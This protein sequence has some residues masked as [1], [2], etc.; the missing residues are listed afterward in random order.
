MVPDE[1]I[2]FICDP[3]SGTNGFFTGW[4]DDAI[5]KQVQAFESADEA[6]KATLWPQIQKAMMDQTPV[7]NVMNLPFVQAY[8][9]NVKNPYINAL[10]ANRL[11][12]TWM[13]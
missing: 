7:I 10:G 1:Y 11:E 4:H 3:K 5:W 8:Q 12:D 6:Q 9:D 2:S 13:A